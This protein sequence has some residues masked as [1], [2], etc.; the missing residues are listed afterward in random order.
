MARTHGWRGNPPHND[1]EAVAL[2]LAATRRCLARKRSRTTVT[3]VALELGVSRATVYRYFPSTEGLMFASSIEAPGGFLDRLARH[4]KGL[5]DPMEMALEAIAF[6]IEQLPRERYLSV[7]LSARRDDAPS[8]ASPETVKAFGR[9]I[10]AEIGRAWTAEV[11][12]TTLEELIEWTLAVLHWTMLE[13][14]GRSRK[15]PELRRYLRRWLG[16]ALREHLPAGSVSERETSQ[17]SNR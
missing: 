13:S 15:G 12:E 16:P 14:S 8:G 5:E 4:V 17:L 6:T 11:D 2:I 9:A 3:D 10:L 7:V 1:D